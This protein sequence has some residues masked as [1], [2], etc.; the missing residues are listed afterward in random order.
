VKIPEAPIVPVSQSPQPAVKPVKE[1]D[2]L[3]TIQ[4]PAAKTEG[5][6]LDSIEDSNTQEEKMQPFSLEKGQVKEGTE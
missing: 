3:E 4:A 2:T 1:V 6:I 5:D